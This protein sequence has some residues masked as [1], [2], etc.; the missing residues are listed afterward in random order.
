MTRE[1]MAELEDL[2]VVAGAKDRRVEFE[3]LPR[4]D[5]LSCRRHGTL[6]RSP[7]FPQHALLDSVPIAVRGRRLGPGWT[8][9]G[10]GEE[11]VPELLPCAGN[12]ARD[13]SSMRRTHLPDVGTPQAAPVYHFAPSEGE[14][15]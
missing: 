9:H 5:R 12:A 11:S 1:T 14:V 6:R 10:P 13:W 3:R 2:A 8:V 15:P 4:S 7:L